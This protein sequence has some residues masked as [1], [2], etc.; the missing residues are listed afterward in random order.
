MR[1]EAAV[2]NEDGGAFELEDVE[3]AA[4]HPGE[5]LVRMAAVGICHTDEAARTG[6]LPI[7]KPAVLGHEGAGIVEAVGEGVT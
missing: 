1:I 6:E 2:V 7:A 3:L 4:P 5:I